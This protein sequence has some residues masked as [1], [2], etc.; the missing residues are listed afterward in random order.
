MK[1]KVTKKP[2]IDEGKR[3]RILFELQNLESKCVKPG[4]IYYENIQTAVDGVNQGQL[5]GWQPLLALK[6][7]DD[8]HHSWMNYAYLLTCIYNQDKTENRKL[9]ILRNS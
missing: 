1:P 4:N 8:N 6:P 7:T 3:S 9:S 2:T 5:M